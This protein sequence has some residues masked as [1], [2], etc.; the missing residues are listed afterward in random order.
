MEGPLPVVMECYEDVFEEIA[1]KFYASDP[2]PKTHYGN[3]AEVA[4]LNSRLW[5]NGPSLAQSMIGM[6]LYP[7]TTAGAAPLLTNRGMGIATSS[8]G[9]SGSGVSSVTGSVGASTAVSSGGSAGQ[10]GGGSSNNLESHNE[11]RS[12]GSGVGGG[13]GGGG[14]GGS[15]RGH[16]HGSKKSKGGGRGGAN[17]PAKDIWIEN[18]DTLSWANSKV[19]AYNPNTKMFKCTDCDTVGF[20]SRIAEHWLGSHANIKVF[21]CPRCPYSSAWARCVRMHMTRHH[22]E[23]HTDLTLWKDNPMLD[24]VA[25]LLQN[26]KNKVENKEPGDIDKKYA[27]PH[28]PYA[29]DRKDLFTRHENIHRDD[30]PFHCYVCYKM[31]NRADHVK[32]HFYRIHK[33]HVYDINLIRRHPPKSPYTSSSNANSSSTS[34][35]NKQQHHHHHHHHQG[36][37]QQHHPEPPAPPP[38]PPPPPQPSAA[39]AAAAAAAVAAAAHLENGLGGNQGPGQDGGGAGGSVAEIMMALEGSRCTSVTGVGRP[40]MFGLSW[41]PIVSS[42]TTA[43]SW[44]ATDATFVRPIC[45][46]S[47]NTGSS[48]TLM[49][50]RLQLMSQLSPSIINTTT[51]PQVPVPVPIIS[52]SINNNKWHH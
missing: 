42:L 46:V 3:P 4:R 25:K 15:G 10:S 2:L 50:D 51:T 27:C 48:V 16:G 12:G 8:S 21:Q 36:Q 45:P 39:A 24:E 11:G 41:R 17:N 28:C 18:K 29:T 14:G 47:S 9:V 31:F 22:N 26:L 35:Y 52:S 30:K 49:K 44:T 23:Q 6:P 20:L 7:G 19:A 43:T 34:G 5:P 32:K 33:D 13:G 40:S 37:Q 38:Q 1:N